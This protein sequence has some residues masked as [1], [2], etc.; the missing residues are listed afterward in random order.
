[1][2]VI[3]LALTEMFTPF[4]DLLDDV[5]MG[6]PDRGGVAA[7]YILGNETASN[8]VI[9]DGVL[10]HTGAKMRPWQLAASEW[11]L[12]L[13]HYDKFDGRSRPRIRT[14]ESPL[15]ARY[16]DVIIEFGEKAR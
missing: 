11:L 16:H 4:V 1:M 15:D 12:Y 13:Q 7:I 6:S 8:R 2:G 5:L 9:L 3:L 10:F 14:L